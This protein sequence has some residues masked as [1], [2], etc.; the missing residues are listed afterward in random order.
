[1]KLRLLL[2]SLVLASPA[3][4]HAHLDSATPADGAVLTDSPSEV[5]LTFT[6]DLELALAT[7]IVTA[8]DG[9]EIASGVEGA[10]DKRSLRLAL[11]ELPPG[12]YRVEWGVTSVDTHGT[13]GSYGFT[14]E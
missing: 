11:P 7:L 3:W 13:T 8:A 5:V 4:S 6:E 10:G 12:T 1:M 2:A 14:L 9:S